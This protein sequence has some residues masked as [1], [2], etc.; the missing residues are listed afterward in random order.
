MA[1]V[2]NIRDA[3][4]REP[5]HPFTIELVGGKSYSVPH[6]EV[7][8]VP[9]IPRPRHVMLWE[10]EHTH[11]IDVNLILDV[12]VPN[13]EAELPGAAEGPASSDA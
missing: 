7:M 9:P 2:Q 10:R 4:H 6:P 11:W 3:L 13:Q 12:I 8:L 1:D 5:F